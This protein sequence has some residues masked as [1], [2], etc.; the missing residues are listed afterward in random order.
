MDGLLP[1]AIT[2][3]VMPNIYQL[4]KDGVNF[5]NSHSIFS[6]GSRVNSASLA[7][8]CYPVLLE[9]LKV[10]RNNDEYVGKSWRVNNN[11]CD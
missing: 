6:T 4:R 8:E 3:E 1:D 11:Y 5:T 10:L 7:S 9:Y 2:P